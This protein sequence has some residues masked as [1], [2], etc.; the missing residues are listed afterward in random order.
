[1]EWITPQYSKGQINKAGETLIQE[2]IS[3]DTLNTALE[4][5]SNWKGSH[6]FPLNSVQSSL[7]Y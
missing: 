5:L 6:V 3:D 1:M 2:N 4:I 7:R